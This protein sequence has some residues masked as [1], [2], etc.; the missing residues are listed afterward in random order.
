MFNLT[1][2]MIGIFTFLIMVASFV[3]ISKLKL[4]S[5]AICVAGL[6]V[7]ASIVLSFLVHIP[8]GFNDASI[9][10]SCIPIILLA[11]IYSPALAMI[12]GIVTAILSAFLVPSWAPVHP[13]QIL[14]EHYVTFA[15]LGFAGVFGSDKKYKIILGVLIAYLIKIAAHVFSGYLFFGMYAPEGMSVWRYTLVYNITSK[16]IE[17]LVV[18]VIMWILPVE[19]IKKIVRSGNKR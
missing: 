11:F 14:V 10:L 2:I 12:A 6:V 13:M 9:G 18:V 19:G 8:I 4:D 7:S 3:V 5:K 17:A 16:G 1:D 15:A